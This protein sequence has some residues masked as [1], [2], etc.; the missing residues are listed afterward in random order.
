M[1]KIDIEVVENKILGFVQN[2]FPAK[3][4]EINLEKKDDLLTTIPNTR[5]FPD[6]YQSELNFSKFIHYGIKNSEVEATSGDFGTTWTIFYH[7]ILQDL[8]NLSTIRN[9]ILRY[10]RA[11]HEIIID[12]SEKISR[13]ATLPKISVLTPQNLVDITDTPYKRGGVNFEITI[14]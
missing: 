5:Y 1:G 11:L 8:N 14:G 3:I 10:T 12:N 9:Q 2:D 4:A 13:Y 6:F 7:I